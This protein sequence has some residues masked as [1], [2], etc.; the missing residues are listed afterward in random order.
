MFYGMHH[1][2]QQIGFVSVRP[3]DWQEKACYLEKMAVIPEARGQGA[4]GRLLHYVSDS[5]S[6][7]GQEKMLISIINEQTVLKNWYMRH[8]FRETAIRQYPHLP[9]LVCHMEK[10]L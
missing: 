3:A 2:E 4:A 6:S 1:R 10:E 7:Q 9:F 8:G 5:A